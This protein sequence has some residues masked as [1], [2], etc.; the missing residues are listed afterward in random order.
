VSLISKEESTS[1]VLIVRQ[2]LI[3]C[4]TKFIKSLYKFRARVNCE[5]NDIFRDEIMHV[6]IPFFHQFLIAGN[7]ILVSVSYTLDQGISLVS[8]LGVL[9]LVLYEVLG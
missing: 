1:N 6:L 3:Y 7:I 5:C 2:V 9:G 8:V 4:L